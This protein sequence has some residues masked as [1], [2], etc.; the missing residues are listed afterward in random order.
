MIETLNEKTLQETA[1]LIQDARIGMCEMKNVTTHYE[2]ISPKSKYEIVCQ[3]YLGQIGI[4]SADLIWN[5]EGNLSIKPNCIPC[6]GI[7]KNIS[8]EKIDENQDVTTDNIKNV[9]LL[10]Y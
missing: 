5:K 10:L 4:H 1:K 9:T 8:I 3:Y 7:E 6:L 2:Q